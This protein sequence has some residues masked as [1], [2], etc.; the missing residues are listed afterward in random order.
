MTVLGGFRIIAYL[1]DQNHALDLH[2]IV[3]SAVVW[4]KLHLV[5]LGLS[6]GMGM[7][8]GYQAVFNQC[9]EVESVLGFKALGQEEPVYTEGVAYV[10]SERDTPTSEWSAPEARSVRLSLTT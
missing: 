4:I 6:F 10:C 1:E 3:H 9:H 5:L 2:L 7:S 8:H